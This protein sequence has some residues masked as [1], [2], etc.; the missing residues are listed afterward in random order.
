M[1]INDTPAERHKVMRALTLMTHYDFDIFASCIENM[2]SKGKKESRSKVTAKSLYD[3]VEACR[4]YN[5]RGG[6]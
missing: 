6:E 4:F 3:A 2:R 1:L 5:A